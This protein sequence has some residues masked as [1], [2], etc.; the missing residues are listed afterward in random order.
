ME[1]ATWVIAIFTVLLTLATTA[2]AWISWLSY[3]ASKKQ[4]EALDELTEAIRHVGPSITSAQ[5]R[6]EAGIKLAEQ[7]KKMKR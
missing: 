2:Y 7:K 4:S 3:Q 5:S 6:K 1:S